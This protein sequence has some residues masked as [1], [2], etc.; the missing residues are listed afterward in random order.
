MLKVDNILKQYKTGEFTQTALN[1]VCLNFR[2][3]EFVA[4]LGPS[5]SGKTTLLNIIGGLDKYD[6]GDL[7][8]NGISTKEY[9]AR[10]W[11]SYRNHTIGFVFQ[12]YNLIRH[13]TILSNVELAMT[14]SNVP[15]NEKRKR[16]IKA[17]EQVGLG[18]H[19]NKKP[20]QISGGQMQ[21]VAIARALVNNPRIILAD[22]PTGALDSKSSIQVMN[23]LKDLSKDHLVIMVTHNPEL[24]IEYA[25]RI[26]NLK[27]GKIIS[28]SNP[29][30]NINDVCENKNFKKTRLKFITAL[31]LS[32]NNLMMKKGRTFLTAFA[33]AIGIVGIAL[34]LALSNG[35]NEYIASVEKDMLGNYPIELKKE[36]MDMSNMMQMNQE[37]LLGD[38]KENKVER[39]KI[40]SNNIVAD[41]VK[42]NKN[43]LKENNLSKFKLYIDKNKDSISK[44]TSAIEYGY[45]IIP[46][47]YR[48]DK[49]EGIVHVSPTRLENSNISTKQQE[50]V[51]MMESN[52]GINGSVTSAWTQLV[53]DDKLRKKQ[54]KLLKGSWPNSYNEI[55]LIVT[56]DNEISDYTLYTLG[57]MDISEMNNIVESIEKNEPYKDS[58]K[59]FKY[60]D[61][62]GLEYQVLAPYQLYEKN[63][64]VYI[65]K[66]DDDKYIE[67]QLGKGTK[68]KITAVLKSN[69]NSE[70]SSGIGYNDK[71]T[72]HLLDMTSKSGIVE[73]QLDNKNI[74]VFTGEKFEEENDDE[75]NREE[76]TN[77]KNEG[78]VSKDS[79][80]VSSKKEV[81]EVN[82][83]NFT[84]KIKYDAKILVSTT[85]NYDDDIN[86]EEEKI[87]F[88]V[89]FINENGEL[90]SDEKEYLKNDVIT[91][92]PE[93][94]PTKE[95]TKQYEYIF[96][97]WKSS[98][99]NSYYKTSDLPIVTSDVTYTAVF[100]EYKKDNS[101][102]NLMNNQNQNYPNQQ[103][104]NYTNKDLN[105]KDMPSNNNG[106]GS[107]STNISEEQLSI[108]LA[109]MSDSTPST[110]EEVMETL[111][112][113]TMNQPSTISLYPLDLENK[114]LVEEFIDK[115]NKQVENNADKVTYTDMIGTL[116]SSISSIV[117]II[118]YILISF[119]AISL[120]VSSI[121]IAIITYI[122]VLERTKEIGVLR[123]LGASKSDISK[124]FNAETF[125]EGLISGILGIIFAAAICIP[126][127][128]FILKT[129][130]IKN[131]AILPIEYGVILIAISVL[132]TLL[133]GFLPSRIAA[134]K[135]PVTALRSE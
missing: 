51:P 68:V 70:I 1:N 41:S 110:Y 85:K 107:M 8:I 59:S 108:M 133:A 105:K 21:R 129:F 50:E 11:D 54:Y 91:N 117:N 57:L 113:Y 27:D 4:I 29:L 22:E 69:E 97:G 121:M 14:I 75:A 92:I 19:I 23:L 134:K 12:N 49:K 45:D 106:Y 114:E 130:E 28:D 7:I 40:Y 31:G 16:A 60:D 65:D 48:N 33:G 101:D 125:I 38:N 39:N 20:N 95:A 78:K 5:G 43:M 109:Q 37:G 111:G 77:I 122:S 88:K 104:N 42:T 127:N 9:N 64:G 71:L 55:A 116:T 61:V 90:L 93:E 98:T 79:I 94:N 72:N 58:K 13:Q 36:S 73:E 100:Y 46:Q 30:D 74:N 119:V 83:N 66:S 126:I 128:L 47:V 80:A 2:N 53:S 87:K 15:K 118:S 99:T 52:D 89:K 112:Y 62:L 34:I 25:T 132:L 35:V 96:I 56:E 17:L 84:T 18:D 24:A 82:N 124:I 76:E 10:D 26:I 86:T 115:Y 44:I 103:N 3:N 135:D 131:I 120:I 67:S 6:S 123:S 63:D 102:E 32:L 81:N